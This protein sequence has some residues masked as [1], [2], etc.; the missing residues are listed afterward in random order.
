MKIFSSKQVRRADKFTIENEPIESIKLMERAARNFTEWFLR[1]FPSKGCVHVFCGTGNNGGDGLAVSRLLIS[2]GWKVKTY[3]VNPDARQSNDFKMNYLVLK[4]V[5][6]INH[7][8]SK[9]DLDFE[10]VKNDKV[11]DALFGSGLSRKITGLYGQV[12]QFIND[13]DAEIISVDIPSGLYADKT[14]TSKNIVT[15]DHTV[16]FQ[17]PKLAFFMPENGKYIKNFNV[18]DIGLHKDFLNKEPTKYFLIDK[19][20]VKGFFTE[21]EKYSFKNQFGHALIISGSYGKMGA[22]I[23]ASKSCLRM[24]IGLVTT[25]VPKCGYEIMQI[26]VPEAMVSIDSSMKFIQALPDTEKY[27]SV[28]IGPGIDTQLFTADVI[29]LLFKNHKKPVVV[30]ADAINL[31]AQ[32]NDLIEKIPENSILTPHPGEFKRLVGKWK[33]DFERLSVQQKWSKKHK[34]IIVLK[35][36][37]TS[38][39]LPDG[40][41]YFNSTGNPGMATGGSG[42]VL[43]GMITSLLGQGM[44]PENSAI[45]GVFIHGLAGDLAKEKMNELSMT[46]GD[47][48]NNIPEAINHILQ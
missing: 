44:S 47:I 31:I 36:A 25:H 20:Y 27:N 45:A 6:D 22:C 24:G 21:R 8:K 9:D 37:H 18:V 32:H 11:I 5:F 30:D 46:A 33:N 35:G 16:S 15:A 3:V 10:I 17:M 40:R 42:D 1:Y 12:I 28:G 4:E 29:D 2:S 26:S 38:V 19:G 41:V 14:S 13:S 7:I 39:S 43:T 34:V 48:I 23:L